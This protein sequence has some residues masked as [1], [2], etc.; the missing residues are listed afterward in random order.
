MGK[1]QI[2]D[3]FHRKGKKQM[4]KKKTSK[5]IP[6]SK[7]SAPE[8]RKL[9]STLRRLYTR[10]TN[11]LPQYQE[12][13][14]ELRGE[15]DALQTKLE[16]ATEGYKQAMK[17]SQKENQRL[18][19]VNQAQ[20]EKIVELR[21]ECAILKNEP[22]N[23]PTQECENSC[24]SPM[25][26]ARIEGLRKDLS[27]AH[28]ELED[29]NARNTHLGEVNKKRR[30]EADQQRH[31]Y[32]AAHA[33]LCRLNKLRATL[34]YEGRQLRQQLA[35]KLSTEQD[36][37]KQVQ[38]ENESLRD[39]K[40]RLG[41]R[42]QDLYRALM[43]ARLHA[44]ELRKNQSPGECSGEP[45]KDEHNRLTEENEA[46]R[47]ELET[48][49]KGA[50]HVAI[51]GA[52]NQLELD[53][54]REVLFHPAIFIALH[55]LSESEIRAGKKEKV[56]KLQRRLSQLLTNTFSNDSGVWLRLAEERY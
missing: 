27:K 16:V 35:Q 45:A 17:S 47:L 13:L 11:K 33:E 31:K 29:A 52:E 46:L 34:E 8:L 40:A 5:D 49:R 10:A 18:L 53:E 37:L 55:R 39:S 43:R 20:H 26:E 25:Y 56:I 21:D 15:R 19:G 23:P 54:L 32:E 30:D 4:P 36:L 9:V 44:A 38:E 6:I 48:L 41:L 22:S 2:L 24:E 3:Q 28:K 50:S 51:E 42:N 14:R 12:E 1:R 7:M